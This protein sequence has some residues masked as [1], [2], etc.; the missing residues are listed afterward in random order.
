MGYTVV[1]SL[2]KSRLDEV[3]L[4]EYLVTS[5][6]NYEYETEA[7]I[8]KRI[9][10]KFSIYRPIPDVHDTRFK[11]MEAEDEVFELEDLTPS[12]V[13]DLDLSSLSDEIASLFEQ[14]KDD[15]AEVDKRLDEDDLLSQYSSLGISIPVTA[16][17][18]EVN[19]DESILVE[20]DDNEDDEGNIDWGDDTDEDED[21][22][23]VN[24]DDD[25][26][27]EEDIDWVDNDNESSSE[28]VLEESENVG[29][30]EGNEVVN[31]SIVDIPSLEEFKSEVIADE[32]TPV[33][34]N[35][36][37]KDVTPIQQ[38]Y[39]T[40]DTPVPS[41]VFVED[42]NK[43]SKNTINKSLSSSSHEIDTSNIPSDL[44]EFVRMYPRVEE[45][46]ALQFY[47]KRV[48]DNYALKGIIFKRKGKLL[49]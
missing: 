26:E 29:I 10:D 11:F 33:S 2:V 27:N 44:V 39:K 24:W 36:V 35:V 4:H 49:I 45:K 6:N 14:E 34:V 13:E 30:V 22:D 31:S 38:P 9:Y 15:L 23:V 18:D 19:E 43:I 48:I 28:D 25:T 41:P 47:D 37:E 12:S 16:N 7:E 40:P 17:E 32:V 8:K 20:D 46:V 42:G 5:F 1:S 21:E 3:T